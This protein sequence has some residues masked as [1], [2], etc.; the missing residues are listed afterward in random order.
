MPSVDPVRTSV[1]GA[2]SSQPQLTNAAAASPLVAGSMLFNQYP[3]AF[4]GVSPLLTSN[5]NNTSVPGA[6]A[7]GLGGGYVGPGSLN[8]YDPNLALADTLSRLIMGS[9]Q[10]SMALAQQNLMASMLAANPQTL[11]TPGGAGTH[12]LA[13]QYPGM[14]Q[15]GLL[16]AAT[17]QNLLSASSGPSLLTPA[18]QQQLLQNAGL[19]TSANPTTTLSSGIHSAATLSGSAPV[20]Q[21]RSGVAAAAGGQFGSTVVQPSYESSQPAN[22]SRYANR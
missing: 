5:L 13:G 4:T 21:D 9:A 16:N 12:G 6:N 1:A 14:L 20:Q 11:L 19:L 22:V 8:A 2:L 3:S 15:Q 10:Q 7:S 18:H 17:M